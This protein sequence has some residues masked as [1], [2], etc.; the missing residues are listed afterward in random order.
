MKKLLFVLIILNIFSFSCE[1]NDWTKEIPLSISLKSDFNKTHE[2][3]DDSFTGSQM[4]LLL[5]G[6]EVKGERLQGEDVY[7]KYDEHI[8]LDFSNPSAINYKINIPIGTY[9]SLS[10][11]LFFDDNQITSYLDGELEIQGQGQGQNSQSSIKPIHFPLTFPSSK[12]IQLVDKQTQEAKLIDENSSIFEIKFNLEES[13]KFINEGQ[14]NGLMTASQN[15]N[16]IDLSTLAGGNIVEDINDGL[17]STLSFN[18][19]E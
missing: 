17:K 13:F 10:A 4:M 7:L 9:E 5:T 19:T 12:L 15:Q 2:I 8:E 18:I 3:D 1:K 16:Q 11:K 14:W 6:V